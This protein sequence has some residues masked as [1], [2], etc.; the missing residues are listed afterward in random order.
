[1]LRVMKMIQTEQDLRARTRVLE[2][3]KRD[4]TQTSSNSQ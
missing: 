1:M 3:L 4:A 2:Q